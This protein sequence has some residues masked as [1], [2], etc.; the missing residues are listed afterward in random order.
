MSKTLR[1]LVVCAAVAAALTSISAFSAFAIN[2][3]APVNGG[4]HKHSAMQMPAKTETPDPSTGLMPTLP[5]QDA[6][7]AIAEIIAILSADPKTDWSK[8]N[9]GVLREHLVDMNLVTLDAGARGNIIEGGLE[10]I[11]SGQGRT[12]KAIQNM[13]IAHAP[14]LDQLENWSATAETLPNGARLIVTSKVAS[15]I[16][17]I[18]GL[19]FFGLMAS[20][21]NH[22]PHH[23]GMARGLMVHTQ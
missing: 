9:I 4:D 17:R 23:I 2:G 11:V 1:R 21:A 16:A 10:I 7:G 12:L 6:F 15:E 3:S 20:G 22:Q 13:V 18:R 5:G 14:Q 19:G 8:V